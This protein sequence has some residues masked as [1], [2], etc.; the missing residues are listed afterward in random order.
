M[1]VCICVFKHGESTP[2][3]EKRSSLGEDGGGEDGTGR[4]GLGQK[5]QVSILEQEAAEELSGEQ[6][7]NLQTRGKVM[8]I[9]RVNQPLASIPKSKMHF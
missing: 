5:A 7:H 6:Q 4:R 9:S 3:C 1:H 8:K 2:C